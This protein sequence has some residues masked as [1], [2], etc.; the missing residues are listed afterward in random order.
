MEYGVQLLTIVLVGLSIFCQSSNG[1]ETC[2][3]NKDA[4][5]SGP[6]EEMRR[7]CVHSDW[8]PCLDTWMKYVEKRKGSPTNFVTPETKKDAKETCRVFKK[9]KKCALKV[10][11]SCWD[12]SG[13][14]DSESSK[15]LRII[16]SSMDYLCGEG[17]E[18]YMKNF[19]C[20]AKVNL[21][22]R[23]K[24][25]K[26]NDMA[27]KLDEK[28]QSEHDISRSAANA[29]VK[30][31][32]CGGARDVIECLT[33]VYQPCGESVQNIMK[34][35]YSATMSASLQ[36]NGFECDFLRKKVQ[37]KRDEL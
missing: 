19:D 28:I 6:E 4:N 20:I 17:H 26:C 29:D 23:E 16:E 18:E 34:T 9:V 2:R 10:R 27:E 32:L 3:L 14:R 12:F 25:I 15:T 13:P 22:G 7:G 37:H 1:N 33:K 36:N 31:S 11:D 21:E 24:T 35:V 30:A 5:C 8:L